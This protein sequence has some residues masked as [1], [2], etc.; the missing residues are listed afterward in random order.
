MLLASIPDSKEISGGESG[1]DGEPETEVE[2]KDLQ[3][4][5]M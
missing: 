5:F 4:L 2:G 3:G 1:E